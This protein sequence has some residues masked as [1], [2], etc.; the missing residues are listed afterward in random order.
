MTHDKVE[1][2]AI[3]AAQGVSNMRRKMKERAANREC[4]D[5][6]LSLR[7]RVMALCSLQQGQRRLPEH[8]QLPVPMLQ[9]LPMAFE[10][11]Q[12]WHDQTNGGATG[13]AQ[14]LQTTQA[15]GREP[16]LH[17]VMAHTTMPEAAAYIC[18]AQPLLQTLPKRP[19]SAR[20]KDKTES[21][22]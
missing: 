16:S 10:R 20:T 7:H 1:P 3:R 12:C 6:K 18:S 2:Q 13:Q 8:A 14:A 19:S 5:F 11:L 4:R 22:A 17:R 15:R 21:A 9:T